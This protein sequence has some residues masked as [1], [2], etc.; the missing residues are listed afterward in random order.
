MG[1]GKDDVQAKRVYHGMRIEGV[2]WHKARELVAIS[3][4]AHR[5]TSMTKGYRV[6]AVK[7]M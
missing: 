4:L 6:R 2:I 7:A 3:D 1:K 5:A